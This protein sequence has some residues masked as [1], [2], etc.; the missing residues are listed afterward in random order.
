MK[1]LDG[2]KELIKNTTFDLDIV[3]YTDIGEIKTPLYSDI[4]K[5]SEIGGVYYNA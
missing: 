5:L 2:L 4:L 3:E 1:N